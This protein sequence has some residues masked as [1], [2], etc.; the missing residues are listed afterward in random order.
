MKLAVADRAEHS[1]TVQKHPG[2]GFYQVS[3]T[4]TRPGIFRYQTEN[5]KWINAVRFKEDLVSDSFIQSVNGSAFMLDHPTKLLVSPGDPIDGMI[6]GAMADD[7]GHVL[8]EAWVTSTEAIAA[9]DAGSRKVS[10]CFVPE[11]VAMSD[12]EIFQARALFPDDARACADGRWMRHQNLVS[13]HGAIVDDA[14]VS[15][16]VLDSGSIILEVGMKNALEENGAAPTEAE[17]AT[18]AAATP[19]ADACDAMPMVGGAVGIEGLEAETPVAD[20]D[21]LAN[22]AKEMV[23][24]AMSLAAKANAHGMDMTSAD[25]VAD[26]VGCVTKVITH[27]GV[28]LPAELDNP[29]GRSQVAAILLS[30]EPAATDSVETVVADSAD[31]PEVPTAKPAAKSEGLNDIY[32]RIANAANKV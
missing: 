4:L 14:R 5:G 2:T 19:A 18:Q 16:A 20:A 22:L 32:N 31:V 8:F 30:Q 29:A 7:R 23:M 1:V 11:W 3:G 24:L 12:A 27:F 15:G 25:V 9:I 26:S 10:A 13:N 28:T 6:S 21:Q 17:A